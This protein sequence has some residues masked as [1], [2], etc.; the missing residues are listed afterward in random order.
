[1]FILR[2]INKEGYW[3][4]QYITAGKGV[5]MNKLKFIS[6]VLVILGFV[7]FIGGILISM[8]ELMEYGLYSGIAGIIGYAVMFV[9]SSTS[10]A[11]QK[12]ISD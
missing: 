9:M 6:T 8:K 3:H 11:R 2:A 10:I 7:L 12:S 4:V 5:E 1:M